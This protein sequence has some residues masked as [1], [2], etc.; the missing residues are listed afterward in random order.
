M[1]ART[2]RGGG[3]EYASRGGREVRSTTEPVQIRY[4]QNH[5]EEVF[6]GK[7]S[8]KTLPY[9]QYPFTSAHFHPASIGLIEDVRVERK[10]C[11]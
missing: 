4:N 3:R 1:R 5:R 11:Q 8:I 7:R 6:L 2:P 10:Y 9:F